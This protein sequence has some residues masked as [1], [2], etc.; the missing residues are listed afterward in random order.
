M[1]RMDHAA[2]DVQRRAHNLVHAEPFEAK[3]GA[4]DVDDRVESTDFVQVHLLDR[5][6]MNRGLDFGQALEQRF[7]AIAA[8]G[9]QRRSDRS[10]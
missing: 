5:H 1:R 6:V 9:G 3:H 4:D 10:A 2:A 8:G 7:R